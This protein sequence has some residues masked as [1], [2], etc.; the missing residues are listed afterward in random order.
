MDRS[1][2][3]SCILLTVNQQLL[4]IATRSFYFNLVARNLVHFNMYAYNIFIQFVHVSKKKKAKIGRKVIKKPIETKT[5][6]NNTAQRK[7]N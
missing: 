7:A 3:F 2:T 5:L 4:E 6:T 1:E